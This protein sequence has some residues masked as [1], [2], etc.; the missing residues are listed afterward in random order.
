MP[1]GKST[2]RTLVA[3]CF[4]S[5][6]APSLAVADDCR[7]IPFGVLTPA[8]DLQDR[9]VVTATIAGQPA[10]ALLDMDTPHTQVSETKAKAFDLRRRDRSLAVRETASQDWNEEFVA[11]SNIAL[12]TAQIPDLEAA[13][14]HEDLLGADVRPGAGFM[15]QFDM[16]LDLAHN[17]IRLYSTK[18][19]EG[20][21]VY[22]S[23]DYLLLPFELTR[24]GKIVVEANVNGK[25]VKAR[26]APGWLHT[27]VSTKSI[28]NLASGAAGQGSLVL[29]S[30]EFG[31]LKL[32]HVAASI[33]QPVP[34]SAT[35]TGSHVKDHIEVV[36]PDVT[37][38]DDILRKL[39]LYIAIK[40]SKAYFTLAGAS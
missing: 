30:L 8:A 32:Q 26:I 4:L 5:L 20:K 36:E 14:V 28:G 13:V 24:T 37:I 27:G 39:R 33:Y 1:I 29:D 12:G 38:G 11:F 15:N 10:R 23:D 25:P 9:L 17:A 6:A 19:C 40:E 18:H 35:P 3:A 34:D 16:E 22:W 31:G 2:Y 7:L 21:V